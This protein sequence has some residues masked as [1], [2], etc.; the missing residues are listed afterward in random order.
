MHRKGG[1][2]E[3]LSHSSLASLSPFPLLWVRK[4]AARTEADLYSS[5]EQC[6]TDHYFFFF[7]F[8]PQ[9]GLI[10]G[11]GRPNLCMVPASLPCPK[12]CRGKRDLSPCCRACFALKILMCVIILEERSEQAIVLRKE[13]CFGTGTGEGGGAIRLD[14]NP[15]PKR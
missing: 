9:S 7:F 5:A 14:R 10:N 15:V 4:A 1:Q 12:T 2:G 11:R 3:W 8:S 6:L 13:G